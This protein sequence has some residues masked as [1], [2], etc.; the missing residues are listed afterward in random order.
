MKLFIFSLAC[1]L[2]ANLALAQTEPAT[3]NET[4]AEVSAESSAANTPTSPPVMA[5]DLEAL[6]QQLLKGEVEET[7]L[8]WLGA[9]KQVLALWRPDTSG[10]PFGAVLILHDDGEHPDW[11]KTIHPLRTN[12]PQFGWATLAISMPDT[13]VRKIPRR[14]DPTTPPAATEKNQD[15]PDEDIHAKETAKLMQQDSE[16]DIQAQQLDESQTADANQQQPTSKEPPENRAQQHLQY[17]M[18]YLNAN[19]QFN[20]II[21]AFGTSAYRVTKYI[22]GLSAGGG[23]NKNT[24]KV[25]GQPQKPVRALILVSARNHLQTQDQTLIDFLSDSTMPIL[26]IYFGDHHLDAEESL[27]RRTY[28][29][30]N[31]FSDYYQTKMEIP[32]TQVFEDETPLSRR[33]RGFIDKHARGVKVGG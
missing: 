11:P 18:D 30:Q 21:V 12:L 3:G 31:N 4:P 1:H 6:K 29:R 8:T 17:A 13:G 22:D 25:Q 19:G 2:F 16:V 10:E 26:D 24:L 27:A 9:D 20:I 15:K 5:P 32:G 14:P 23:G 33:I 7:E 28:T